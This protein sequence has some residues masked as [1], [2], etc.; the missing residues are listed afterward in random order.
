MHGALIGG[1]FFLLFF[2]I[3]S[4]VM[5]EPRLLRL[6]LRAPLVYREDPALQPFE[7]AASPETEPAADPGE[8]IFLFELDA[9]QGLSIE[10]DPAR[11]LGPLVFSGRP[12]AEGAEAKPGGAEPGGPGPRRELPAGRY[13]F[14]QERRL[15]NREECIEMAMEVQKDG[16][17]ERLRPEPRLYLRFLTEDGRTVSQVFRPYREGE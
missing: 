7:A 11:L 10:P 5:D 6:E 14:A 2:C 12:A 13:L 9:A 8:T 3:S 16:L 4:M 17:W 1:P 15:L